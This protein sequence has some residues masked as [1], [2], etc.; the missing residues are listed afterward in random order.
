[1]ESSGYNSITRLFHRLTLGSKTISEISFDIEKNILLRKNTIGINDGKHLFISGLARSGTTALLR[2]LYE[3]KKFTSLTYDDM[4]F[5]LA[6]NLWSKLS[7]GQK[8]TE[9]KER[10]HKDGIFINNRSPEAFDE[11]F[12]KVFLND[13]YICKDRLLINK[14]SLK[15]LSLFH[16]YIDLI[17][18]KYDPDDKQRYLSKNNNNI[19]RLDAILNTFPNCNVIIPFR[20]PLQQA[21]SL[22]NQHLHFC[23]VQMRDHFTL[24]Y[25]NW[26]GHHEFGL[27]QKP[28]F[29]KN[30]EIFGHMSKY[31]KKDINYW[32]LT[33]L[34]YYSY[35]LDHYS[36]NCILFS[37]EQFCKEPSTVMNRLLHLI[38]LQ[39]LHLKLTPFELK[40]RKCDD[41]DKQILS[42]C[43]VVYYQLL[44]ITQSYQSG[45]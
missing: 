38:E 37:Y 24:D 7:S 2:N 14:P 32:L 43:N 16:N 5:V 4:P 1:M 34:N 19:L 29:L 17:L 20:D 28:F 41:A 11:V 39:D 31:E 26:I 23:E 33:W 22:L 21:L 25:M 13:N 36:E 35:V 8:K 15:I 6:P 18:V 27:N 45:L 30:E 42:S 10:A 44:E 40:I 3:T 12:W 9:Y